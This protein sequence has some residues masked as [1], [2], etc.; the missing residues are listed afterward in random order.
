ME[1]TACAFP[2]ELFIAPVTVPEWRVTT[3]HCRLHHT[4]AI[5]E[6]LAAAAGERLGALSAA[7]P[8]GRPA[9]QQLIF[10]RG[11]DDRFTVSL[12]SS[13]ESLYRRGLKTHGGPAPI[14]ETLAAAALMRAGYSGEELLLDPMC[15]AGTFAL[16]AALMAKRRPPGA[17]REFA[18]MNWPA[19]RPRRWEFLKQRAGAHTRSLETPIIRASDHDPRACERLESCVRTHG[20]ADAV[21]VSCRDFFELDPRGMGWP[22]GLIALNPPYG[23]RLGGRGRSLGQLADILGVLAE[24]YRGWKVLLLAPHTPR[25]R[26]LPF[27]AEVHRLMHG[28]IEIDLICSRIPE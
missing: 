21:S 14:R 17:A 18:F 8:P 16:E 19:F 10:V 11:I 15:G 7:P 25:T 13:G 9:P 28:G 3:H 22:P 4:G 24:R 26:R 6:R 5:A 27:A 2:W 23:R 12:D 1:K 20:L